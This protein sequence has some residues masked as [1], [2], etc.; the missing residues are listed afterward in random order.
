MFGLIVIIYLL[1]AALLVF[2]ITIEVNGLEKGVE[3]L[4]ERIRKHYE[5]AEG[6]GID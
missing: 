1:A 3:A 2:H 4:E 6:A 5:H